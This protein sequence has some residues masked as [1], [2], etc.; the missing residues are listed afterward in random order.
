MTILT[1]I[2]IS[3]ATWERAE[4]LLDWIY[5]QRRQW[6]L[7]HCLIAA[8]SDTHPEMKLRVKI[9]ASLAFLNVAEFS[10]TKAASP[11]P[12]T[13]HLFRETALHL[14]RAT[15]WP[16]VWLE[17]GCVPVRHDWMYQ[18]EVAYEMQPFR[19]MGA[20]CKTTADTIVLGSTAIYPASA[21]N[22]IDAKRELVPLS[23]K[24]RLFQ[25]G[26]FTKE[27]KLDKIRPN[28]AL[29]CSS[30]DDSLIPALRANAERQLTQKAS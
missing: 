18:L 20:H 29:F 7:E 1:V 13:F 27:D 6:P 15:R 3:P 30:L 12:E 28:A 11:M 5:Q 25:Y 17:P 26:S 2:P 9:S 4:R 14:G 19:Y 16:W 8:S 23:S 24:C 10:A 21:I 22:D